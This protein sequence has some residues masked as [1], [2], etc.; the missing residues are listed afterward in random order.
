MCPVFCKTHQPGRKRA[1]LKAFNEV[2]K[3]HMVWHISVKKLEHTPFMSTIVTDQIWWEVIKNLVEFQNN[4]KAT[5]W[6]CV[7][8]L[9]LNQDF[10]I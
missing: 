1:N 10:F 5:N 2:K 9:T 3:R 8:I 7:V 4:F 6:I